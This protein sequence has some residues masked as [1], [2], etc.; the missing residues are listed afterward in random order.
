MFEYSQNLPAMKTQSKLLIIL[1]LTIGLCLPA[2]EPLED[3]IRDEA[4]T[5]I[6]GNIYQT[7]MIDGREWMKE[8][9]RVT[10]YNNG[11]AIPT[12]LDDTE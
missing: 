5:D 10:R 4:L 12:G 7:V 3:L 11:D 8:S 9:L 2:C 6:D 1:I